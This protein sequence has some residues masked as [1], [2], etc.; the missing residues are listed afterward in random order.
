[1]ADSRRLTDGEE[2]RPASE[3]VGNVIAG[4]AID[5]P[6]V[7]VRLD[8]SAVLEVLL[9]GR[10]L[11][12]DTDLCHVRVHD[13]RQVVLEALVPV[14]GKD[15]GAVLRE[16]HAGLAAVPVV[17]ELRHEGVR[18][19]ER[20][21]GV[22]DPVRRLLHQRRILE[23]VVE[24]EPAVR[25]DRLVR[26]RGRENARDVE[27]RAPAL[28]VL[29]DRGRHLDLVGL[30]PEAAVVLRG[31]RVLRQ[32]DVRPR[33]VADVVVQA[34]DP[35]RAVLVGQTRGDVVVPVGGVVVVRKRVQLHQRLAG[36][37]HVRREV[38]VR[39]G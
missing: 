17:D 23:R 13:L 31:F 6:V 5:T 33:A 14:V 3:D 26:R 9:L 15:Q 8:V 12:H 38:V 4:A 2:V 36:R 16:P 34:D 11:D 21:N 10:P 28:L 29:D 24:G 25:E 37:R 32:A 35:L 30:P 7:E 19:V 27:G 18:R 1:M 39:N 20:V 22:G